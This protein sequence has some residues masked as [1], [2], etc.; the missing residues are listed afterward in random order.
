LSPRDASG[1]RTRA[2]P[3]WTLVACVLASSLSFVEGSVLS[4]AL[5]AI[6]A[7]YGAGGQ[8]VQWVVNA[9]LLPL[10]ALL[11][12][13]GALGDHFGRR[14]LLV[15]GTSIFAV[16]SLICAL[17]PSL[18]VLLGARAAQGVGAALLLP[19]SLALLNAAFQGEK[20]GRAVGIW[21]AAGAA[22]AAIAPLIGGWLVGTVGWPA[23][24][25][26]NLPL[27]FGAILLALR[28]VDESREPGAGRTDYAGAL[29]ATAGLG[30]LTYALT[31]WS[32]TRHFTGAALV[33]LAAGLA[34][35]AGFLFVEYRRG[36][37]AMVP[38]DLFK[39]RCFTGLNLLTFLLYGAFGAAMLLIPYVLIT[40]GGYSPVKAGLAMLPLPVLMTSLSPTMGGLAAKLGPR[41]PL[42]VGPAIV[43]AGMLLS[44][45][46]TPDGSY[47]AG[48]FPMILVMAVGMTIAVAPLTA[49]VLGSVE[50]QHV[51]MASG[52]NS[53]VARTGG[54]IATALLGAVLASKGP[55]LF[56][57]F[58]GAMFVSA[59]VAA[60]AA[61]TALTMLGG[62]R[63]KKAA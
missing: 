9:Y 48:A 58:H 42:T 15:I 33:A 56:A 29:L 27:A 34:C 36:S 3:R 1:G 20:R 25:Y 52:F 38:L 31:L 24:F 39:G 57:G 62:V 63:M 59:G 2:D 11:L 37:R 61:L 49:S 54:L 40:S 16:T 55:A 45:M 47:W 6:R 21:A 18:P 5:P 41:I 28:F 8:Q 44:R 23:I 12:L 43:A 46:V 22:A 7:S 51:A 17:A 13:G 4:V 35:L 10:S 50:E 26:I 60:L 14:R 19:N 53:A 30:G 32:A